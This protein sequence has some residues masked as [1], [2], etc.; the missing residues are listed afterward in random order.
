MRYTL[1]RQRYLR[2]HERKEIRLSRSSQVTISCRFFVV[3]RRWKTIR[4]DA[5]C[6][7][8]A[9]HAPRVVDKAKRETCLCATICLARTGNEV[10]ETTNANTAKTKLYRQSNR[11]PAR[12]SITTHSKHRTPH[13]SIF[14]EPITSLRVSQTPINLSQPYKS[15]CRRHDPP[16]QAQRGHHPHPLPNR[17]LLLPVRMVPEPLVPARRGRRDARDGA[18]QAETGREGEGVV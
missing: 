10:K 11:T 8:L 1:L 18:P 2:R 3:R 16:H 7:E 13:Q 17:H 4:Y 12:T 5:G 15:S 6:K 9:I 14:H